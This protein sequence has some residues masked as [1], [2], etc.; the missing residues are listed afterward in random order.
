MIRLIDVSGLRDIRSAKPR[1]FG[2]ALVTTATV[3]V[4]GVENGIIVAVM[5]SIVEQVRH[6]YRPHV[7]CSTAS[8]PVIGTWTSRCPVSWSRPGW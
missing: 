6:S 3:V 2:L 4:F 8:P 5:L 1:E 7:R